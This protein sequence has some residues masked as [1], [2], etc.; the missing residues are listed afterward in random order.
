MKKRVLLLTLLLSLTL[1]ASAC[2]SNRKDGSGEDAKVE[3]TDDAQTKELLSAEA[4]D[5]GEIELGDYKGITVEYAETTDKA[6]VT[7]DEVQAE[8]S[9]LLS[10]HKTSKEIKNRA[11]KDGDIVN[12]DYKGTKDE[13]AFD[14]GTAEGYDLTIGSGTFIDGFE[15]GLIGVKIGETKNLDLTFPEDYNNEELAGQK[16]VFEVKVNSIRVE[17]TPELTD[18]F[19]AQ[20]TEYKTVDEYKAGIKADLLSHKE[21]QIKLAKWNACWEV[22]VD[23]AVVKSFEKAEVESLKQE[24]TDYYTQTAQYYGMEL[25]DYVTNLGYTMEDFEKE[26]EVSARTEAK[27]RMAAK[28]IA[29]IENITVTEEDYKNG[30]TGIRKAYGYEKDEDVVERITE[31]RLREDFLTY[32]VEELIADNAKITAPLETETPVA[33]ETAE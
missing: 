31:E 5:A 27:K 25:E 7:D 10:N 9:T 13:V 19:V 15:D 18:D 21:W 28:K 3:A 14:G 17:K 23:N 1:A 16:V 32:K 26:A 29:E 12:I 22:A 24:M 33:T 20:N 11:V 6:E 2:G 4:G 30:V 8:V